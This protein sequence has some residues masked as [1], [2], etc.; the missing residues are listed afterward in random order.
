MQQNPMTYR[1][2]GT[3]PFKSFF[4]LKVIFKINSELVFMIGKEGT[5]KRNLE[6]RIECFRVVLGFQ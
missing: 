5:S 3:E 2:K 6:G 4:F 1:L